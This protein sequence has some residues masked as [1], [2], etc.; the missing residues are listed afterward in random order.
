MTGALGD[1]LVFIAGVKKLHA[2]CTST[3]WTLDNSLAALRQ[4]DI[5][6]V[7]L[8]RWRI[9][10]GSRDWL[11][12]REVAVAIDVLLSQHNILRLVTTASYAQILLEMVD[13]R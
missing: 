5:E 1:Q 8:G 2:V 6:Q 4:S 7:R 12:L 9:S 10:R 13:E 11:R 3:F